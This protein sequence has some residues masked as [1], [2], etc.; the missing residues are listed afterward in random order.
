MLAEE[1]LDHS[2]Q[3]FI[4]ADTVRGLVTIY[5][6]A[7]ANAADLF[8]LRFIPRDIDGKLNAAGVVLAGSYHDLGGAQRAASARYDTGETQWLPASDKLLSLDVFKDHGP[9]VEGRRILPGEEQG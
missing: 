4:A 5:R 6:Q 2:E 3:G 1:A 9:Q 7:G 8:L